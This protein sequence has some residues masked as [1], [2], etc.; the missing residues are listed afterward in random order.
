MNKNLLLL[1]L[2]IILTSSGDAP[3]RSDKHPTFQEVNKVKVD[4]SFWAP[5]LKQWGT[6]TANDVF[7]KFEAKHLNNPDEQRRQNTFANFDDVA[8][9]KKGTNHHAG[10]PW[11]DGLIYESIRGVSDFLAANPDTQMESR[12]D[13][14]VDRIVAA[15]KADP[16]GYINT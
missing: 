6:T 11:F 1:P 16:D 9:G 8:Q 5:R 15:Q 2:A 10:L 13:G 14:Y 3:K 4:D 12:I 7:D